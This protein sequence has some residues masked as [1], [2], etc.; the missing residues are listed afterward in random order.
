MQLITAIGYQAAIAIEDTRYYGALL[1]SE[2]L[3]AMGQTIATLSHDVKNILQGISGGAYLI[4]A[5]LDR[6]DDD[7]I[8]R[9]W[10]IVAR[11]QDRIS[12]LVMDMLT[13]SKEREIDKVDGDL[14]GPIGEVVELMRER[15]ESDG[16]QLNYENPPHEIQTAFDA[17]AIHRAVLNLVVNAAEAIGSNPSDVDASPTGRIDITIDGDSA[18]WFIDIQ[19]NGPGIAPERRES[20]FSMFESDK[21][22][23][24]TGLGLAVVA[25][26][27]RGHDGTVE[28]LDPVRPARIDA[29]P[30]G[31][32]FRISLPITNESGGTSI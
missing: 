23:R 25:K 11:N 21:G 3:A 12:N 24:G 4:E 27:V 13:F 31:V 19:D 28:I 26:I 9:G 30:H 5:G 32:R 16:V 29:A 10:G 2:R 17:E 8:R 7:A 1:Q 22:S 14:R 6:R 15:L 20:V 18:C